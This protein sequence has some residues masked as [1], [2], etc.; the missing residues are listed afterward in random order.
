MQGACFLHCLPFGSSLFFASGLFS[1]KARGEVPPENKASVCIVDRCYR[2]WHASFHFVA[3]FSGPSVFVG[4][5]KAMGT[6]MKKKTLQLLLLFALLRSVPATAADFTVTSV[7]NSGAGTLRSAVTD[8]NASLDATNS[9]RFTLAGPIT[10]TTALPAI[11]RNV[12]FSTSAGNVTLTRSG[13]AN[14]TGLLTTT[15]SPTVSFAGVTTLNASGSLNVSSIRG[16]DNLNIA[17]SLPWTLYSSTTSNGAYGTYSRL[18][19]TIGG[20]VSGAITATAGTNTAYGI[21]SGGGNLSIGGNVSAVIRATAATTAAYGVSAS[22]NLS[23][24]G[25]VSGDI[26]AT[27]GS[28]MAYGFHAYRILEIDGDVSGTVIARVVNGSGAYGIGAGTST[29]GTNRNLV[30]GGDVSGSVNVMATNGSV[31]Y[32]LYA[33]RNISI[34]G[35]VSGYVSATADVSDA[36]GLY[37]REGG[38]NGVSISAPLVVSGSVSAESA[39]ASAGVL[40]WDAMNLDITGEVSATGAVAYAIRSGRFSG[41]GGFS[42]NGAVPSDRVVLSGDGALSGNVDLRG[43]DDLMTVSDSALITGV[44]VLSGGDGYDELTFDR[45]SG[46][47][48]ASVLN[49][50]SMRVT[51]GS[52]L[53][54]G[55]SKDLD[56]DLTIDGSSAV[57]VPATGGRYSL[58]GNLSN[59]G[60]LDLRNASTADRFRIEG[61][62]TGTGA[63]GLDIAPGSSDLLS[64]GG[65]AGGSTSLLLRATG[66]VASFRDG[67]PLLLAHVD[68][69][70]MEHAFVMQAA[71]GYGPYAME[72]VMQA[73]SGGGY[74]WYLGI[75]GY[76]PEAFALQALVPFIEQ[77]LA[78]SLPRFSE[79]LVYSG[80]CRAAH[81]AGS[82]WSRVYGS[83]YRT[84]F[85]GDVSSHVSGYSGGVQAGADLYAG[86]TGAVSSTAGLYAGVGSQQGDVPGEE[87]EK[88]AELEGSFMHA[89]AYA[90][91]AEPGSYYVEWIL[92]AGVHDIG[93]SYASGERGSFDTW[94]WLVS[95]EAGFQF[96]LGGAFLLEPKAQ[97]LYRH[98]GGFGLSPAATGDISVDTVQGIR[99]LAGAG[100][101]FSDCGGVHGFFEM[102]MIGDFDTENRV[103]YLDTDVETESENESYFLGL[104]AGIGR[105][106]RTGSGL[107]YYIRAGA[108]YGLESGSS[109]GYTLAGGLRVPL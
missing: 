10:L 86:K 96:S 63:L 55:A 105:E 103:R 87:A 20:D 99:V 44:P 97:V 9:I 94:S 39:G 91:L 1:R 51:L 49:W 17:G 89:G 8:L 54:L 36:A 100:L 38:I 21:R 19:T 58:A 108:L 76:L 62:Y 71:E 46:I 48:G 109:F 32:G 84:D 35:G 6:A 7:D 93:L 28:G 80:Y 23:I 70:S 29:S 15:G 57:V 5:T 53:G 95:M 40:S 61:D 106:S 83:R 42:D 11:T 79:R 107:D 41:T 74:D 69:T 81:E 13:M 18:A 59:N 92:Q 4:A 45:W 73:A 37:A 2:G 33:G 78:G 88:V 90:T 52:V 85:S 43:G 104:S 66:S 26:G 50:E 25:D 60:L 14:G 27:A 68:G 64:V 31:A 12:G 67:G 24:G 65:D 56:G 101:M 102:D 75:G 47:L 34:A 16:G 3:V 30:I 77:P 82:I 72:L 98:I 22:D